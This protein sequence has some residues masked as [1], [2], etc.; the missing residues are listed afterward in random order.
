MLA[1]SAA[2]IS[3]SNSRTN[4]QAHRHRWPP[5]GCTSRRDAFQISPQLPHRQYVFSSGFRALVA[6]ASD[7]H[8]GHD[9]GL[10][11]APV[12]RD[13]AAARLLKLYELTEPLTKGLW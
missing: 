8:P 5:F 9:V 12:S 1:S 11:T 7:L 3:A 2:A 6:I 10:V 4:P 13:G